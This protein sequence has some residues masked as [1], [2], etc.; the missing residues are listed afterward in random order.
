MKWA[1]AVD[2]ARKDL[3]DDK[4]L[5]RATHVPDSGYRLCNGAE[6][7][8]QK[9]LHEQEVQALRAQH[10]QADGSPIKKRKRVE[11][12][13]EDCNAIYI[14]FDPKRPRPMQDRSW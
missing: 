5:M 3:G 13:V 1:N 4:L 7:M 9:A 14:M 8:A 12:E 11:A 6:H 2:W 10:G